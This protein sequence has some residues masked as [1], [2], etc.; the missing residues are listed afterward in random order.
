[1]DVSG[2]PV[3]GVTVYGSWSGIVK[4]GGSSGVTGS[5]GKVT[6][7]SGWAKK[8]KQ[9]TFTFTVNN[10]I[11]EG[12]TCNLPDTAPSASISVT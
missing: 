3:E 2:S 6:F 5:D 7:T 4:S 9:G 11:K 1:V 8:V 10:V 12:W